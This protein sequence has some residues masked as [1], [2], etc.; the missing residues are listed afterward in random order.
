MLGPPVSSAI[1]LVAGVVVPLHA[2]MGMRSV[3]I[4]YV[5]EP[6]TQQVALAALAVLTVGTAVGLTAFNVGDVGL[7]RGIKELWVTQEQHEPA[8]GA[9]AAGGAHH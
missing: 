7:T 1:D 2:H 6:S 8:A 4:D 3:I 5:H 9:P